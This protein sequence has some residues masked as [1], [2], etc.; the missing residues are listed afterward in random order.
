MRACVVVVPI[1][2]IGVLLDVLAATF[3]GRRRCRASWS[4]RLMVGKLS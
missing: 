1:D 2:A 3:V 4:A